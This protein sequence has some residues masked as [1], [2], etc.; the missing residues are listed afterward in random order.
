MK[1]DTIVLIAFI[2]SLIIILSSLASSLVVSKRAL[3]R[4]PI[5]GPFWIFAI[6]I[7]IG[8]VVMY[9]PTYFL[10]YFDVNDGV[11]EKVYKSLFLSIHNTMRLFVLDGEFDA[12]RDLVLNV[13]V[14]DWLGVAYSLYA[15]VLF[16]LAPVMTAGVVLTFFKNATAYIVYYLSF[17][18]EI[19]Y[20]TELNLKSVILAENVYKTGGKKRLIVFLNVD[21][22]DENNELYCRVKSIKAICFNNKEITDIGFKRLLGNVLRK[23]YF[24]SENQDKNVEQ[25]LTMIKKLRGDDVYDSK[26]THFYVFSITTASSILLDNADN[27]NIKLRR[28][29]ESRNLIF[30]ILRNH[31]IFDD[32]IEENGVKKIN[33]LILGLGEYGMELFKAI[34]WCGQMVGYET[35]LHI[36]A[37]ETEL[38][39]RIEG[40]CPELLKFNN[41][42]IDGEAYYNIVFHE[43]I[44]VN[45]IEFR[46]ELSKLGNVTTAYALLGDDELNINAS[47][48]MREEFGRFNIENGYKIPSI[49]AIV[50]SPE[51][52]ETISK[53]GGFKDYTGAPYGIEL[54]GDLTT[55]YSLEIIEQQELEAKGLKCHLKWSQ[56]GEDIISDTKKFESYEYFRRAS[57]AEALYSELRIKLGRNIT[58]NVIEDDE[59]I[60]EYEHRRWNAYMRTEGYVLGAV[61]SSISKTHPS[62]IPY[63]RLS[64]S[65]KK[66][67]EIVLQASEIND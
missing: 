24:I 63:K 20:F 62:L 4:K 15:V 22:S 16:V 37:K 36:V 26:N 12:F 39:E 49:Y 38:N 60:V 29:H 33:A 1:N 51:K 48:I 56:T 19:Y 18:K 57:I 6:G 32:A 66:K 28:V 58:D 3:K 14:A 7:F 61:K 2:L 27:G 40:A 42:K 34:C 23:I 31:S 9:Y 53:N 8:A 55:E 13:T 59:L 21:L 25:A 44:D 17:N 41:K 10:G 5:I 64:E 54:I 65:E 45:T 52:H 67:D 43:G 11:F 47:I 46:K 50:E 30:S 35:T